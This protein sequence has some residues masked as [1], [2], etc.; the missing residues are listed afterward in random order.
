LS[1]W[2][3]ND[4]DYLLQLVAWAARDNEVPM[5]FEGQALSSKVE[6]LA[7]TATLPVD[8]DPVSLLTVPHLDKLYHE[9]GRLCLGREGDPHRWINPECHGRKCYRGFRINVDVA[10]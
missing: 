7:P 6:D 2:A 4:P 9:M 10:T 5:H 1:M 8:L 3:Y